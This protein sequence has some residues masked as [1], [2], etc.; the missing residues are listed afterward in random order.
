MFNCWYCRVSMDSAWSLIQHVQTHHG[1][2][3]Y[4]DAK[5]AALK[6]ETKDGLKLEDFKPKSLP[7]ASLP[8]GMLQHHNFTTYFFRGFLQIFFKDF[9]LS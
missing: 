7:E 5:D 8:Q 3:C 6:P 9:P 2:A 1:I 4:K